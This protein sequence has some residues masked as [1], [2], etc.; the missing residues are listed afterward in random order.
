MGGPQETGVSHLSVLFVKSGHFSVFDPQKKRATMT[1]RTAALLLVIM[2]VQPP[3]TIPMTIK[4]KSQK[5][6]API[7]RRHALFSAVAATAPLLVVAPTPANAVKERNEA[8]CKTGFFTNIGQ[9]YCTDIGN[10][11]DEGLA[12]DLSKKQGETADSLM[13]K[14]GLSSD[15]PTSNSKGDSNENKSNDKEDNAKQ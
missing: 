5:S 11:A 2:A 12:G 6:V 3:P 14:L 4:P 9:W 7:S 10:I 1:L 15:E 8:L 13:S